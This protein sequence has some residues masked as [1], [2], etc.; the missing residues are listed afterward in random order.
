MK[1]KKK[2]H[3][4]FYVLN[5]KAERTFNREEFDFLKSLL[6]QNL[7]I[8]FIVIHAETEENVNDFIGAIKVNLTQNANIDKRI[9]ELKNKFILWN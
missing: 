7:D 9:I 8:Y 3:C 5:G 2:I 1:K 6:E 4:V